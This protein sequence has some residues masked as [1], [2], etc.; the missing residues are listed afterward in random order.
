MK[1]KKLIEKLQKFNLDLEV[2]AAG[3]DNIGCT[4]IGAIEKVG[5]DE[6]CCCE[7]SDVVLLT[8]RSL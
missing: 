2:W 3:Y 6:G 8:F 5:L 7:Q 1:V 4:E